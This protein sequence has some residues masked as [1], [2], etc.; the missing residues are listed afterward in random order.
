[1]T[2]DDLIKIMA[3]RDMTFIR[4]GDRLLIRGD[5]KRM[6]A[7]MKAAI[8][9]L[10]PKIYARLGLEYNATHDD[11]PLCGQRMPV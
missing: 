3:D 11:C 5:T 1:M 8:D 9:L 4:D 2:A 10:K 7:K 6:T